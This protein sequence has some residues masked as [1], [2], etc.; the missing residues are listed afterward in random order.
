MADLLEWLHGQRAED[1][2]QE[3]QEELIR[4][5]LTRSS[6]PNEGRV[7]LEG[8][9]AE[10]RKVERR[11]AERRKAERRRAERGKPNDDERRS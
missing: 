8:R 7:E 10:R 2:V 11:K 3:A 1:H 9:R 6:R 5:N 4:R